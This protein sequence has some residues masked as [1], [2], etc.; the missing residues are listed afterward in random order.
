MASCDES[1]QC[2]FYDDDAQH[3][4]DV[5]QG[6]DGS[7]TCEVMNVDGADATA[8]GCTAGDEACRKCDNNGCGFHTSGQQ[9]CPQ[10]ETCNAQGECQGVPF[11]GTIEMPEAGTVQG[12]SEYWKCEGDMR[13]TTRITLTSS[14]VNP[15][16]S[17]HQ[18]V[19]SDNSIYGA[20][21]VMS[22]VGDILASSPFKTHQGCS[23]CFLTPTKLAGVTLKANT[24]Y[25]LGFQNDASKCDMSG[26]SVYT[27]SSSR[28][29]GPATFDQPRMDQPGALNLGLPSNFAGWQNRWQVLCD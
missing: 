9:L 7:G 18:Y 21:Y 14:C 19:N 16:I 13:T 6:C 4:C 25:H 3:G 10:G 29:V 22:E 12:Y 15:T 28:T 26:P 20:Y 23:N 24:Y 2:L 17:I 8:L 5:C 27:D 11:S 1:G